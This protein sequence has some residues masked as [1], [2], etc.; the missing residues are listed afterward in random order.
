MFPR[1]DQCFCQAIVKK[2]ENMV[3]SSG[4]EG[5]DFFYDKEFYKKNAI[6]VIISFKNEDCSKICQYLMGICFILEQNSRKAKSDTS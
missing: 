6:F 2:L 3:G 1:L 4:I 5:S